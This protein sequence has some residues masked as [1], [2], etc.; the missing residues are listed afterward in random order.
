MRNKRTIS[1]NRKGNDGS[2]ITGKVKTMSKGIKLKKKAKKQSYPI[3]LKRPT[4]YNF[5]AP[6]PLKQPSP[7]KDKLLRK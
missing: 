7:K 1:K 5:Y 2:L 3:K 6:P 4:L